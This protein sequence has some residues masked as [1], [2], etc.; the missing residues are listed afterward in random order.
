[1]VVKSK[2]CD[3][4][5]A[6]ALLVQGCAAGSTVDGRAASPAWRSDGA[7]SGAGFLLALS[8]SWRRYGAVILI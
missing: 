1:V 2:F 5:H 4:A 6:R 3:C 8:L 7:K